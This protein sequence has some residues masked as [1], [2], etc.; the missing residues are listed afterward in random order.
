MSRTNSNKTIYCF[1]PPVIGALT[2]SL[3]ANPAGK[4][5]KS[6]GHWVLKNNQDCA[7][8]V[9]GVPE[10][11][12][13]RIGLVNLQEP[14]LDR[15][16]FYDRGFGE[17]FDWNDASDLS[18]LNEWRQEK[19]RKY[20]RMSPGQMERTKVT[21][22]QDVTH[23]A[24]TKA[25][26]EQVA[27]PQ[28]VQPHVAKN[29]D[30]RGSGSRGNLESHDSSHELLELV[31]HGKEVQAFRVHKR[32]SPKPRSRRRQNPHKGQVE[33]LPVDLDKVASLTP[34]QQQRR[35]QVQSRSWNM[36]NNDFL[37]RLFQL[38]SL[39]MKFDDSSAEPPSQFFR[40]DL[41]PSP[42]HGSGRLQD[43]TA[44][45]AARCR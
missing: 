44:A 2:S 14:E 6:H 11:N 18:L 23:K 30:T 31:N 33:F 20:T 28:V 42:F 16:V 17:P 34:E 35:Y 13:M 39:Q 41:D 26:K 27:K 32:P 10:P 7:E 5:T 15:E 12:K 3:R 22:D 21:K 29:Q 37:N 45:I 1:F 40:F 24:V 9:I 4:G 25:A 38:A 8:A 36:I 19:I 43:S